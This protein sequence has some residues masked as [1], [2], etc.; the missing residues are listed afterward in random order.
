MPDDTFRVERIRIRYKLRKPLLFTPFGPE[1]ASHNEVVASA[2]VY[3]T[4]VYI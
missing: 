1:R 3:R 4:L 2:K